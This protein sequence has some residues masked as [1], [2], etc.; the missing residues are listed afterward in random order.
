MSQIIQNLNELLIDHLSQKELD[1]ET[2]SHYLEIIEFFKKRAYGETV[3]GSRFMRN[4][5]QNHSKYDSSQEVLDSEIMY[6]LV[7]RIARIG[8]NESEDWPT[9]LLGERP[10]S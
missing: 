3:T 10:V 8:D 4:F 9:D 6:D 1:E 7:T 5:V 2:L